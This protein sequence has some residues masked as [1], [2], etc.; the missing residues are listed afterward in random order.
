M[1]KS[2]LLAAL[3]FALLAFVLRHYHHAHWFILMLATGVLAGIFGL[4]LV[5]RHPFAALLED[6][7]RL[8][9]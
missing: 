1:G 9:D 5:K 4:V 7:R 6:M 8:A 2:L 3:F